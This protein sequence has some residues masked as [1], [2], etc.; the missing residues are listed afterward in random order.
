FVGCLTSGVIIRSG[1]LLS[2]WIFLYLLVAVL[3]GAL[4]KC[5][6]VE[7]SVDEVLGMSDGASVN[8][9]ALHI[10]CIDGDAIDAGVQPRL[11]GC[12]NSY[13]L[14]QRSPFGVPAAHPALQARIH[15]FQHGVGKTGCTACISIGCN[16]CGWI[17]LV[18]HRGGPAGSRFLQ[19]PY[20]RCRHEDNIA[21]DFADSTGH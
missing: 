21:G 9:V 20:F 18:R 14:T 13:E 3:P 6:A 16:S 11:R 5:R 10:I 12:S 7:D 19:L 2:H 4:D 1:I 8:E 15:C 17:S